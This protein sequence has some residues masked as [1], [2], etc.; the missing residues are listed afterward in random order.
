MGVP[1]PG[2]KLAEP[3]VPLKQVGLVGTID[4]VMVGLTV[5]A[6]WAVSVQEPFVE[7]REITYIPGV[8]NV[9]VGLGRV[10]KGVIFSNQF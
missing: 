4:A 6:D 7:I 10:E 5:M 9:R 1:P 8:L 3:L 2:V